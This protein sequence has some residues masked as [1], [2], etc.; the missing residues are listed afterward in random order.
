MFPQKSRHALLP[1]DLPEDVVPN[2]HARMSFTREEPHHTVQALA[3][4]WRDLSSNRK[5][6]SHMK[7][8]EA[9]LLNNLPGS[10]K[11]TNVPTHAVLE[12]ELDEG[13]SS[14]LSSRRTPVKVRNHALLHYFAKLAISNDV[15]DTMDYDFVE[16]LLKNGASI[17]TMDKHGQTIFHEVA[18]SWHTDVAKFLIDQG[19]LSF[20]VNLIFASQ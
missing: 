1:N 5:Y 6:N 11:R 16:S 7:D 17:N 20:N 8:H 13:E 12:S 10:S 9:M 15:S 14:Q 3:D 2:G 18:R 19:K 4:Q